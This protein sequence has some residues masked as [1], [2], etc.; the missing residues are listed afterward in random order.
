MKLRYRLLSLLA[1]LA[2]Y[3]FFQHCSRGT[4]ESSDESDSTVVVR[5][6]HSDETRAWLEDA[7]QRFKK[8]RPQ[9]VV[10]LTSM[11]SMES[12][13]A[14]VSRRIEPLVWSPSDSIDL[15]MLVDRWKDRVTPEV[16]SREGAGAPQPMLLSPLVW[17]SWEASAPA[18]QQLQQQAHPGS[19]SLLSWDAVQQAIVDPM[20]E[21]GGGSDSRQ[22]LTMG[23]AD[24]RRSS[25]GFQALYLLT[26]ESFHSPRPPTASQLNDLQYL[27][28]V[29]TIENTAISSGLSTTRLLE[30]MLRYG[31]SKFDFILTYE[32]LAIHTL[33]TFPKSRWGG[34]RVFYPTY[35]VWNDHPVVQMATGLWNEE[36]KKAARQWIQFLLSPEMQTRALDYGFRPGDPNIAL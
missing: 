33:R 26:L 29:R 22:F 18:L 19:P 10:E 31:P 13:D 25:S 5:M 1:L 4:E 9:I 3:L 8:Q 15:Y 17:L 32:S 20:Q 36:E 14:I 24:P 28:R 6:L 16:F 12:I 35:T 7:V 11:G 2:L 21:A 23:H 27:Q 30:D 34:L